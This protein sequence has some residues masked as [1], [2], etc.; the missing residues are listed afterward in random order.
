[1]IKVNLN[2]GNILSF[3]L[4]KAPDWQQWLEWSSSQDFQNR[5]TGIGILHDRRFHTVPYPKNFTKVNVYAESVFN[6]KDGEKRKLGERVIVHADQVKLELLV[7]TYDEP[8]PPIQSRTTMTLIG[9]QMFSK[10]VY[11]R[12]VD[13]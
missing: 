11:K 9:R 1:V 10:D 12:R 6:K 7:Y 2:D 3:D 8:K 4:N 5:I 13:P